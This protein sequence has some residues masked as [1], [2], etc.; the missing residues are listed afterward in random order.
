[1]R[2]NCQLIVLVC[3]PHGRAT[4]ANDA[5]RARESERDVGCGTGRGAPGC[6]SASL[7]TGSASG[8][9]N[10]TPA[11]CA[12]RRRLSLNSSGPSGWRP[13]SVST[14]QSADRRSWKHRRPA[15]EDAGDALRGGLRAPGHG[16]RP[17]LAGRN[18]GGTRRPAART[19]SLRQWRRAGR[20]SGHSGGFGR[21][22]SLAG[23]HCDLSA[24][25]V[26]EARAT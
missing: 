9:T 2:L 16:A 7:F 20:P 10:S 13:S 14:P 11:W 6:G 12:S 17:A 25:V 18:W 3:Q 4:L 5:Q 24:G 26:E 22:S 8:S 21:S 19:R 1:M 15:F 23:L